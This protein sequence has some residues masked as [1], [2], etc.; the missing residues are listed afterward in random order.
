MHQTAVLRQSGMAVS[1]GEKHRLA[2]RHKDVKYSQGL[3]GPQFGMIPIVQ[4]TVIHDADQTNGEI[5]SRGM[6]VHT[7]SNL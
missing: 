1:H 6:A 5:Y 2:A 4:L 3:F 7:K